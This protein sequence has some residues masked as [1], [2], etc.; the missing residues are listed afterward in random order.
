M[1]PCLSNRDKIIAQKAAELGFKA[2][3]GAAVK[4]IRA[5]DATGGENKPSLEELANVIELLPDTLETLK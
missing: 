3:L 5:C 1:E 4:L 2:G